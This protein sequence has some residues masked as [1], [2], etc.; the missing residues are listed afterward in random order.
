[1]RPLRSGNS[2]HPYIVAKRAAGVPLDGLRVLPAD[3]RLTV[4]GERMAG[5]LVVPV[6][7]AD[8]C[9]SSLQFIAAPEVA[10]RL[11][12]KGRPGKLNLPG[13]PV[14]GSFTVGEL[15]PGGLA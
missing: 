12:A 1:M 6:I 11:K 15:L 3:D 7:R 9:I 13:C 8:G 2:K 5:A 14:Q 10:A 4:Q